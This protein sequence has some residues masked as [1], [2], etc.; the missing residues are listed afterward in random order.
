MGE[1][2]QK[3]TSTQLQKFQK[4]ARELEC[5]N[6]EDRFNSA[7]TAIAKASPEPKSEK[8]KKKPGG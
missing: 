8:S 4:A 2:S 1:K 7:L 6:S 5:D 3:N